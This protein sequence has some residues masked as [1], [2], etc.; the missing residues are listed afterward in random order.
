MDRT[1]RT[2]AKCPDCGNVFNNKV[3]PL[4]VNYDKLEVKCF[5][6]PCGIEWFE[7]F[8][9]TGSKPKKEKE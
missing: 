5:C 4:S 3:E 2:I 8:D 6:R 1:H 7:I 9:I